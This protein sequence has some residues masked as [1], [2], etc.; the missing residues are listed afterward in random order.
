MATFFDLFRRDPVILELKAGE[1][2]FREGD[3]CNSEMY[4]LVSGE[5]D[6]TVGGRV[7][8]VAQAGTILGEMSMIEE[9]PRTA[10]VTARSDCRFAVIDHKRFDFLVSQTPGFAREVMRVMARRLRRTDS[11]L[12][13]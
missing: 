3:P 10:T 12:G 7:L 4:V 11:L 1:A 8:E 9:A 13:D 5:A 2:F 6:I